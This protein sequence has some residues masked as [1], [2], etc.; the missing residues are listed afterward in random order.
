MLTPHQNLAPMQR[1]HGP[2][3]S[4]KFYA[5][6]E[7]LQS[8]VSEADAVRCR[9]MKWLHGVESQRT[10]GASASDSSYV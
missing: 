6:M 8:D 2:D 4:G 1:T 7:K 3:V 5:A 10:H 9:N